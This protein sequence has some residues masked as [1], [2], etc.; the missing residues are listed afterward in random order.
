MHRFFL[1][2]LDFQLELLLKFVIIDCYTV[3]LQSS[4]EFRKVIEEIIP[5]TTVIHSSASAIDL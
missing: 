2:L 3:S 5:S 4:V 1:Y